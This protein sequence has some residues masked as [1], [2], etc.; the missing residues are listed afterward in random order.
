VP[1]LTQLATATMPVQQQVLAYTLQGDP[2]DPSSLPVSMAFIPVPTYGDP[3]DPTIGQ[4]NT[5]TW[6]IGDYP[7]GALPTYWATCSVGPLA[8]ALTAGLYQ[9]GVQVVVSGTELVQLWGW[10]LKIV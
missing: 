2:T 9:I 6:A 10:Q 7:A 4:W 3:P 1:V 8:T 5:A